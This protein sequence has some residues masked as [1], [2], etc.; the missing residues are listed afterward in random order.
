M[1]VSSAPPSCNSLIFCR[2]A[3]I[4]VS[5][6]RCLCKAS[7]D[8]NQQDTDVPIVFPEWSL[9][10]STKLKRRD[11]RLD[12]LLKAGEKPK[13]CYLYVPLPNMVEILSRWQRKFA[14]RF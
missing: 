7:Y 11:F 6:C 8:E 10:L 1:S 13:K 3:L 5:S 4:L 9:M 14:V 2:S 12:V